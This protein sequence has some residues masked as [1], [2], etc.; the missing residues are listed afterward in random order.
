MWMIINYGVLGVD[1]SESCMHGDKDSLKSLRKTCLSL[2]LISV[3]NPRI[4]NLS[5]LL[6]TYLLLNHDPITWPITGSV[7]IV[8]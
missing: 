5:N 8:P 2:K 4:L 6:S 1:H 3:L 7:M